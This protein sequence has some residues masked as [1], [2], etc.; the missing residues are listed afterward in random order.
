MSIEFVECTDSDNEVY[1][2][3]QLPDTTAPD[4]VSAINLEKKVLYNIQGDCAHDNSTQ[5]R[6]LKMRARLRKK[7]LDKL[8]RDNFMVLT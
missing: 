6:Q 8:E 7:V 5:A 3:N 1:D 4:V 2:D